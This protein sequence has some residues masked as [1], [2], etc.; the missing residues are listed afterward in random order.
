MA[1]VA[2]LIENVGVSAYAGAIPLL[3]DPVLLV[4]A[5]TIVTIEARHSSIW[6]IFN[7]GSAISQP[8]DIPLSASQILAI[9]GSFISG[10][11]LG[12]ARMCS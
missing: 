7:G 8:T 4:D 1:G 5:V 9:A 6:N 2:R 3:D 10:C 11:N 12:V